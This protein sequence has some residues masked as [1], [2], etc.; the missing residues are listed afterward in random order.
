MPARFSPA[1]AHGAKT[2]HRGSPVCEQLT[3][4]PAAAL[5]PAKRERR[6][7]RRMRRDTARR[8][9][10]LACGGRRGMAAMVKM[11]N[12]ASRR[13]RGTASAAL[14]IVA[15]VGRKKG[16]VSRAQRVRRVHFE[17]RNLR[18]A[19]ILARA[20]SPSAPLLS[21]VPH[22]FAAAFRRRSQLSAILPPEIP[23]Q[24]AL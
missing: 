17:T 16:S 3:T 18:A 14:C 22:G 4:Q 11:G 21:H 20:A 13:L 9:E 19:V 15:A 2:A 1:I 10:H 6:N 7:K 23:L 5:I 24:R 12:E 8:R